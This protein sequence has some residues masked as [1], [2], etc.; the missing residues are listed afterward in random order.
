MLQRLAIHSGISASR[1]TS[2]AATWRHQLIPCPSTAP[3]PYAADWLMPGALVYVRGIKTHYQLSGTKT[4]RWCSCY[5]SMAAIL[6]FLEACC[7]LKRRPKPS[8]FAFV[9]Q[10][11]WSD[12]L[13]QNLYLRLVVLIH[14]M[15]TY[16]AV[17]DDLTATLEQV[18]LLSRRCSLFC[19]IDLISPSH[20]VRC[21]I[22]LFAL[23]RQL[24]LLL[25]IP[26]I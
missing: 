19:W 17:W 21:G 26:R 14:S 6:W 24:R 16:S 8:L 15:G 2:D 23:A 9:A 11:N 13:H 20:N 4:G 12:H 22:S 25:T 18:G 10:P 7:A 5:A 1:C 3:V